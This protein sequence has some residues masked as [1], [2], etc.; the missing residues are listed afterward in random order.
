M[1]IR[2]T[3]DQL[4]VF[5]AATALLATAPAQAAYQID[6]VQ[7]GADVVA[8]G[9]GS[10]DLSDL[11]PDGTYSLS[12]A[13]R[14]NTAYIGF[15]PSGQVTGYAGINGPTAMGTGTGMFAISSS[16]GPAFALNGSSTFNN[17]FVPVGYVSGSNLGVSTATWASATLAGLGLTQGTYVWSWGS[18]QNAD[19]VTINIGSAGAV[20][21]PSTWAM[22]L[23]GF[24]II[25]GVM[26]RARASTVKA[27]FATA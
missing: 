1:D 22:L 15:G 5:V 16:T 20:P 13:V 25:G 9:F 2:I 7:S 18:G 6:I 11:T 3:K 4:K 26:R 24:G 19:T 23:A 14:G 12:R 8:T 21:E 10:I 27:I 17:L